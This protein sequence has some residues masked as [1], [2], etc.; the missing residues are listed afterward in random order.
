[1]KAN[2]LLKIIQNIN[3][4]FYTVNDFV[5]LT[6]QDKKSVQVALNRLVKSGKLIRLRRNMYLSAETNINWNLIAEQLVGECYISFE[7]ALSFYNVINQVPYDLTLACL[8]KPRKIKIGGRD[9]VFRRLKKEIFGGFVINEKIKIATPEKAL[10]DLVYMSVRGR[11]S[12]N[13]AELDFSVI[14]KAE[15]NRLLSLYSYP[16][17]VKTLV[18]AM[19]SK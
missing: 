16:K 12:F 3:K 4:S 17:Q 10:L 19:V 14:N 5:K 11:T 15:V 6:E 1:M 7:S 2:E 18:S 8:E 9:L 13:F